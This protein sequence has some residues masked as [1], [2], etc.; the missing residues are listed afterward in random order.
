MYEVEGM[1]RGR[2][3]DQKEERGKKLENNLGEGGYKNERRNGGW[4]EE[5]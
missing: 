5:E 3:K 2:G 1:I 4:G